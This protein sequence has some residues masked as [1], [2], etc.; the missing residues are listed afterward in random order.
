MVSSMSLMAAILQAA[1]QILFAMIMYMA[2]QQGSHTAPSHL[3]FSALLV[4]V[5]STTLL[6]FLLIQAR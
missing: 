4:V 3:Y 6:L 5:M 2:F 1:L